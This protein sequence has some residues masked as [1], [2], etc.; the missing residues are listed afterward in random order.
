[1]G[2]FL[3]STALGAGPIHHVILHATNLEI[4]VTWTVVRGYGRI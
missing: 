4:L 3:I 1:L 2:D